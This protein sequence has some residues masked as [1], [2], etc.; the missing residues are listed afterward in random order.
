MAVSSSAAPTGLGMAFG[1]RLNRF[2]FVL[3]LLPMVLVAAIIS[4][5]GVNVPYGDEWSLLSLFGKWESHQLTF[6]DLFAEHNGHRI[7][8]PRLIYLALIQLTHGNTK[9]EMFFSLFLCILTSAGL[10]ILLRRTVRGSATK[11]LALWA[12]IN[13]FLFSPIQA[14]NWLWGFQLQIFLS[15]LCLVGAIVCATSDRS[16]F[17]R[18]AS[19]LAFGVAGTF[20]FGNGLLIWP[21][22]LF[23]LICRREKVLFLAAWIGVAALVVLAYLPGY[24]GHDAVRPVVSWFDYPLYFFGFLGAPLARIPNSQPL[25]LPVIIGSLLVALFL[26]IAVQLVRRRE[27]LWNA[28]PWLALGAYVIGSAVMATT[29][30]SHL[31]PEHALDSRYTTVSVI[32]LVSLIGLVASVMSRERT[33]TP[34]TS[35]NTIVIA[36]ALVGSL[37]TLYAINAPSEFDYIR[38][39]HDFRARGKAAL[40]FSTILDVDQMIR[41][42]LLIREDPDTL[43]RYLSVLDRLQLSDPPRRQTLALSDADNQPQ[44]SSD[45]YGVFENLQF[46]GPDSLAAS[47]W[48]YLPDDGRRPACV[49]L[50]HRSGEDWKAFALPELTERRPDL[51]TKHKSRGFVDRGWRYNF[52][53]SALPPGVEEISAWAFDANRGLTYRLPGSFRLPR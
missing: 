53:R 48:S 6:A 40:Q 11:H 38:M 14:E 2:L 10:F 7:L 4:R 13:L 18:L 47:G 9:A 8:I 5:Y 43:A 37:L 22:I 17:V 24:Q 32:L 49:V 31:G 16:R 34:S 33:P 30:R 23:L 44:R 52:S 35:E 12:F 19:T 26:G 1:G 28:A 45:E 20:S 41:A 46:E 39:S 50:A 29:A 3:A 36:S 51:V 15:N 42:T 27:G 21:V 25:T